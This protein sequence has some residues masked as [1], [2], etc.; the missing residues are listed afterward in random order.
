MSTAATIDPPVQETKTAP[1]PEDRKA[2]GLSMLRPKVQVDG[3][4]PAVQEPE[5]KPA[6]VIKPPEGEVKTDS[7]KAEEKPDPKEHNIAELR[8][9][10]DEARKQN[11]E[12]AK[13]LEAEKAER[14]RIAAEYE[15]FKKQ[16]APKEFLEKLTKAEQ[17]KE[18]IRLEL[19]AASLERDPVFR[20]DYQEKINQNARIMLD[21]LVASGADPKEANQVIGNWREEEF[22]VAMENMT[23]GQKV[24]FQAA[25]MQAEQIE[26]SRKAALANA[27]EEWKR[28][29]AAQQEH[30]RLQHEQGQ[31]YLK[32]EQ[33]AL[34]RELA[35]QEHLKGNAELLK[36]ARESVDASYQ[37]PPKEIMRHVATA[38]LLAE[39]VKIKDAE[40][41]KLKSDYEELKK[42]HDEQAEFIKSRNG[43]TPRVNPTDPA[44]KPEDKKARANAFLHP[45]IGGQ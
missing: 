7:P 9:M 37:M 31:Q 6:E 40:I 25:W 3:M 39:G 11:E 36:A 10:R 20:K 30:A 32:S 26:N 21:V 16:P 43:G 33:D 8:K 22:G 29:E 23:A 2:F 12:V 5:K 4:I 24:K 38:R 42:K 19:R 18:Q 17:E 15:E 35:E 45:T 41:A 44:E 13:Q 28:R 34:F 27:D 14:A 1:T